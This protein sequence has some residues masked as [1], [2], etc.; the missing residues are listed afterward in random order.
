MWNI[1]FPQVIA[2]LSADPFPALTA[3]LAT[4]QTWLY[5]IGFTLFLISAAVAGIMRMPIFGTSDRRNSVSNLALMSA[6][7]GLMILF[8][9]VPL[10][11]AIKT[12]F[13]VPK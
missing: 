3:F 13:P 1:F 4:I 5:A 6:V 12:A 9:A 2:A 8:L 10:G 11:N 7:V